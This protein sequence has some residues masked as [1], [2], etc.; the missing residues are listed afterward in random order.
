MLKLFPYDSTRFEKGIVL[1]DAYSVRVT[2]EINGMRMLEFSYPLDEKSELISENRIVVCEGQAYRI[3]KAV[4]NRGDKAVLDAEC[5]HV[6][7]ADAPNI[8]IQNMPDMM[9]VMPVDVL[10]KAFS[11][12]KFSLFTDGELQSLGMRR[13]DYD[14]F[15]ID[16]FS[17]DKTNPFDVVKTVIEN[18]GKGEIYADNYKIALVERIGQNTN[19]R[20]D[21]TKNMQNISINRDITDMVTRLYPYG[22]DDMHIGSVNGGCQYIQSA[23]A[24]VYGVREGYRDYSDYIEPEQIMNRALWEFDIRNSERIDIPCVNITGT[25]ADISK[26]AEYDETEQVHLG[27]YVTV[28]DNGNE[29][30]ERII[31]L[32]YYPYQSDSTVISIGRVKKDLFFYLNQ[33]GKLT[34]NY[35]KVSTSTGKV[36]ASSVSGTITNS[37]LSVT[38]SAGEVSIVSDMIKITNGGA[39]KLQLGNLNGEFTC[40]IMDNSG[41]TAVQI[42]TDGKMLFTGDLTANQITMGENVIGINSDG[43]LCINDKEIQITE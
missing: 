16:F 13:V 39:L 31:K 35:S 7:N 17:E 1:N 24:S 26:L 38:T 4:R 23:N 8:H 6:Y 14:G 19:I 10:K 20:L 2:H 18:C 12:T 37:G 40:R 42:G 36:K 29:I 22:K 33:M 25:Y 34:R 28:I 30:S 11:G 15:K 21:L 27:D 41:N 3:I 32:E 43:K 5:H 9:G